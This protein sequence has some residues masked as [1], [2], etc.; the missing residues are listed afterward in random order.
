MSNGPI[1]I[2][3]TIRER[4]GKKFWIR[5][6]SAFHNRDGSINVKLDAL[7]IDGQIQLREYLRDEKRDQGGEDDVPFG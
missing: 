1:L 4:S 5:I 6:G 7:P 2:A 3:Y